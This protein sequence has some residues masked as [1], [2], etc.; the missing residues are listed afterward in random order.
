M[1]QFSVMFGC[2]LSDLPDRNWNGCV[3]ASETL[4]AWT[5]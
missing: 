4:T 3:N 5:P 1:I 2:S